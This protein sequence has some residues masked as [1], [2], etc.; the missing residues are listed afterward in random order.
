M[1][2]GDE[3]LH[4]VVVFNQYK[5]PLLFLL[6]TLENSLLLFFFFSFEISASFLLIGSSLHW[7]SLGHLP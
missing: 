3:Q 2:E 4:L 6:L 7:V 1:P 5:G